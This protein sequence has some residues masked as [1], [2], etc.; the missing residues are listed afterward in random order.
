MGFLVVFFGALFSVQPASHANG[1]PDY[2]SSP[3]ARFTFYFTGPGQELGKHLIGASSNCETAL[4]R[5]FRVVTQNQ[6]EL[7]R[8]LNKISLT[9]ETL[10]KDPLAGGLEKRIILGALAYEFLTPNRVK[11]SE[12][13][14]YKALRSLTTPFTDRFFYLPVTYAPPVYFKDGN[15]SDDA[16]RAFLEDL[17]AERFKTSGALEFEKSPQLKELIAVNDRLRRIHYE[18]FASMKYW[19]PAPATAFDIDYLVNSLVAYVEDTQV[20]ADMWKIELDLGG[21]PDSVLY[22]S[23][24][25]FRWFRTWMYSY[26]LPQLRR[27]A[28]FRY[29]GHPTEFELRRSIEALNDLFDEIE[30][31][32]V[33]AAMERVR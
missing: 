15:I 7:K 25:D 11:R 13:W 12:R 8:R 18:A 20:L 22:A 32:N 2:L 16:T 30:R 6:E 21:K 3:L 29:T 28:A 4:E 14:K 9:F 19:E 24:A 26:L 5:P 10:S 23:I 17:R 33:P 27:L 31:H 1:T